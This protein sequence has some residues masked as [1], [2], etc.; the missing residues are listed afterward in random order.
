MFLLFN[1]LG[2]SVRRTLLVLLTWLGIYLHILYNLFLKW[3]LHDNSIGIHRPNQSQARPLV[4]LL[5]VLE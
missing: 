4:V 5:A 2:Q 3:A 1:P